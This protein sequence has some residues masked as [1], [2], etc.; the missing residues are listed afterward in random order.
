MI[1][2]TPLLYSKTNT[3]LFSSSSTTITSKGAKDKP[4][5][6]RPSQYDIY[7][8]EQSAMLKQQVLLSLCSLID[9]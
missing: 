2:G 9:S 8:Q 6:R 7:I 3:S 1:S 5:S 4:P